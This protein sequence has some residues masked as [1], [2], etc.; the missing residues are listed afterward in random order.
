MR[1]NGISMHLDVVDS[2]LEVSYCSIVHGDYIDFGSGKGRNHQIGAIAEAVEHK[3]LR[4]PKNP[5]G[6]LIAITDVSLQPT[7]ESDTF[8]RYLAEIEP[9]NKVGTYPF[10]CARTNIL[11]HVPAGYVDPGYFETGSEEHS[12]TDLKFRKYCSNNGCALGLDQSEAILHGLNEAIERH[13]ESLLY[14]DVLGYPSGTEW[15]L[16]EENGDSSFLCKKDLIESKFGQTLTIVSR[17]SFNSFVAFSFL[18]HPIFGYSTQIGAGSSIYLRCALLRSIDELAQSLVLTSPTAPGHAEFAEEEKL[19][20]EK[21]RIHRGLDRIVSLSAQQLKRQLSRLVCKSS[22][23]NQPQ[24]TVEHQIKLLLSEL[25]ANHTVLIRW[26]DAGP[27]LFAC[28]VFVPS[29]ERMFMLKKG[30][31]VAPAAYYRQKLKDIST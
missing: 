22:N 14:L 16:F 11:V 10:T 23:I 13:Y 3:V 29:F 25:G 24:L 21:A 20:L 30:K 15:F 7:F 18:V 19:L 6:G 28:Q 9:A 26:F 5:F 1:Q 27:L 17:T 8:V 4:K 31:L 2:R 12:A